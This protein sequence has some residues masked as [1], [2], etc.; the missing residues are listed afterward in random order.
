MS[1]SKDSGLNIKD[2]APAPSNRLNPN[3]A[4]LSPIEVDHDDK[5]DPTAMVPPLQMKLELLKKATGVDSIYDD[6]S[7]ED[8]D[9]LD[10]LK[11]MA[12]IA[13]G[14][15]VAQIEASEDNDITG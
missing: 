4:H 9:E 13:V 15:V 1:Q 5:T 8:M 11:H 3:A 14:P 12:G 6:E 7:G 2:R 10:Q